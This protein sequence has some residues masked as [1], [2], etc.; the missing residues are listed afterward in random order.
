MMASQKV[1]STALR[2]GFAHSAYHLYGLIRKTHP[3][4]CIS[5]LLLSHRLLF[6]ETIN[7]NAFIFLRKSMETSEIL[8]L[9]KGLIKK[10]GEKFSLNLKYLTANDKIKK[11]HGEFVALQGEQ[12]LV[13]FNR[14]KGSENRYEL[15]RILEIDRR[16]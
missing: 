6:F 7:D 14:E 9:I 16:P 15:D 1:R 12:V 2:G 8:R 4:P 5:A 11:R 3:A 13:L 10:H